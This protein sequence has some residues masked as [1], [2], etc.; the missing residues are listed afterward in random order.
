MDDTETVSLGRVTLQRLASELG[1]STATISLAL[2]DSPVVA[3]AT[4]QR[5]QDMARER[6]YVANRGAASLRTARTNI[7]GVGLHDI[8]N[9]S[10]TELLAALED[11]LSGAGKTILLGVSQEDVVRQARTLGTLAEYRPDAFIISPALDTTIADLR[12]LAISGI[13]V[14]QVTREVEGS[15]FDFAGSDDQVGVSLGVAHLVALGHRRIGMIGGLEGTSTGR[16][17]LAGYKAGLAQA[18]LPFDPA[19]H[20]PGPGLREYGREGVARLL[21]LENPP[22]AAVCFND[23]CAFGAVMGVQAAGLEVGADFSIVGYDDIGEAALWHPA[24]TTVY[25]RIPE[26]GRAAA[27]LALSRIAAPTRPVE[28]VVLEP[29]LVVRASAGP[30]PARPAR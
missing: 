23:L 16:K 2:R 10:F 9:P 4:R 8:V 26:Y 11:A 13:A 17:R 6:G 21:A 27:A 25:T 18:G 19:L 24:L 14:V 7:I 1:L 22:T 3:Q 29:K 20:A 15:G 12:A 28:R 5:V 30:P